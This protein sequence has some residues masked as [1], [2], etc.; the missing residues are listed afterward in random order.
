MVEFEDYYEIL[1][2]TTEATSSEIKGAYR[3]LCFTFH[4]DRLVGVSDAVKKRAEQK[5][6]RINKAYDVM[7]H[8]QKRRVYHSEWLRRKSKPKPVV[9]PSHILFR[10]MEPGQIGK[11][12]FIIDNAG[13]PYTNLWVANP[14]SWVKVV[15]Y[16]YVATSSGLLRG[17]QIEAQGNEWERTYSESIVVKLDEEETK[18]TI[19]LRT[20]RFPRSE[21]KQLLPKTPLKA[22]PRW[23]PQPSPR[24]QSHQRG[25]SLAPFIIGF[26]VLAVLIVAG[27][28][29]LSDLQ[30]KIVFQSGSNSNHKICIVSADGSNLKQL[31]NGSTADW[32]PVLSPNGT[33][34]AFQSNR[35][36]NSEIYVIKSDGSDLTRLTAHPASDWYPVWSQDSNRIAF[37]SNRDGNPEIYIANVDGNNRKRL[38]V[39]AASD[40]CPAW[41]PD[42]SRI[43]FQSDRDGNLEI[44]VIN[45]DGSNL[46]RLTSNPASDWYPVWSIDGSTILFQSDRN[47]ASV[48]YLISIDGSNL[49]RLID[50]FVP[51]PK[52]LVDA[53]S[54]SSVPYALSPEGGRITFQSNRNGNSEIYV[55]SVDG[56]N[57]MRLTDNPASDKYPK[58]S[59][60]G[61]KILFQSDRD[62]SCGIYVVNADSSNLKKLASN[63]AVDGSFTW[64][65]SSLW[66]KLDTITKWSSNLDKKVEA[67]YHLN[68]S[69]K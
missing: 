59:P 13:G 38:T 64:S 28:T 48:I 47:G 53:E 67:K 36:G 46:K 32:Y 14:N 66:L 31:T 54:D 8:F 7:R 23:R 25:I 3:E 58:W 51:A 56:S 5:L 6:I 4:P 20:R 61:K 1:G 40:W 24:V 42:S 57:V 50:N 43:A 34:I 19:E 52:K 45:A 15:D 41:S 62:G 55:M 29:M 44:Y 17:V 63:T 69:R 12:S 11:A 9:N 26:V 10:D 16:H 2:V 21:P 22:R 33:K 65:P 30:G 39:H 27:I 68:D 60:D 18:V 49:E 37:Q 35:D